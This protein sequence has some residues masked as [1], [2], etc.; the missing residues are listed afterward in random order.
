MSRVFLPFFGF[1]FG[2]TPGCAGRLGPLPDGPIHPS[3]P[4]L[5]NFVQLP[6]DALQ[7]SGPVARR[8]LAEEPGCGV[9]GV[10]SVFGYTLRSQSCN[11]C[12]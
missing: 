6:D 1:I 10:A 7:H 9:P 8:A 11:L 12:D 2:T 5:A 3:Q 4:R